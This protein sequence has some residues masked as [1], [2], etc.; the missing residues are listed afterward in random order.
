MPEQIL[1]PWNIPVAYF[2]AKSHLIEGDLFS[3]VTELRTKHLNVSV[4]TPL[5]P[6]LTSIMQCGSE[7][8]VPII[9]QIRC[10]NNDL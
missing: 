9:M 10:H 8:C 1:L 6:I 5:Q 7:I 4:Y 2:S 3:P